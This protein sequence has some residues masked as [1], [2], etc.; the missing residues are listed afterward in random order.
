MKRM[1]WECLKSCKE[2]TLGTWKPKKDVTI[3]TPSYLLY[4]R[5]GIVPHITND[6]LEKSGIS[7]E[8]L[9]LMQLVLDDVWDASTLEVMKHYGKGLKS[10][11]GWSADKVVMGILRDPIKSVIDYTY[12]DHS[13][14]VTTHQGRR[15]VISS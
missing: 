14:F 12:K 2:G 10:F 9:I 8:H 4:S 6:M 3:L 1:A 11:Y 7:K 15:E 5:R 13:V